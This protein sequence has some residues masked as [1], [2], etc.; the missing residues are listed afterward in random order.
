MR[1]LVDSARSSGAIV[2]GHTRVMSAG[3]GRG[4]LSVKL[5]DRTLF[6]TNG[7]TDGA[8]GF[9]RRRVVPV[10]GFMVA[11]PRLDPDL[12]ASCLPGAT[13]FHDAGADVEFGR[14]ADQGRRIVFGGCTGAMPINLR[15]I[16]GRLAARLA[17]VFPP[18]AE[19]GIARGWTGACGGTF[20]GVPHIGSHKDVHFAF[21]YNSQFGMPLGHWL[22]KRIAD[23]IL[24]N[25]GMR[26]AF[27]EIPPGTRPWY[28]GLNWMASCIRT[29]VRRRS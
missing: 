20:T 6:A 2:A 1:A 14:L 13:C 9:L 12:A 25:P 23:A 22:G 10:N 3:A 28:R 4:V 8:N 21:G 27:S 16:T 17:A 5:G 11:T 29:Y 18:L 15:A 19:A 26:T 7:Y 24:G